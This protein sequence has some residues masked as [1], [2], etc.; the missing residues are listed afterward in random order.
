MNWFFAFESFSPK[1]FRSPK[2][3]SEEE[4][5][6]NSQIF[7]FVRLVSSLKELK[8][9][10]DILNHFCQIKSSQNVQRSVNEFQQDT[11]VQ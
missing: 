11:V 3:E 1:H 5:D 6:T 10:V 8:T 9:V 2:K 4:N 7:H